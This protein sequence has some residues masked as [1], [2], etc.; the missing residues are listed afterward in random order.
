MENNKNVFLAAK[1]AITALCGGFTAAFGWLGWLVVAWVV[2]MAADW[3]T[4]SAAAA[5]QHQW[6]STTARAGIWHKAGMVAVVAVAA[7]T[8]GVLGA[9]LGNLPGAALPVAY[10]TLICPVVLCWY[11]FTELG[12]ILENAR[13]MGAPVPDCLVKL[14]ADAKTSSSSRS[15]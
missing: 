6:S 4:G 5:A 10:T 3:L 1:A 13:D 7:L 2:C 11:V 15:S 14:L 12:S 8:D 9:A